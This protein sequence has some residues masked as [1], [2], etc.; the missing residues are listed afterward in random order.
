MGTEMMA[1]GK[2]K[3]VLLLMTWMVA[4]AEAETLPWIKVIKEELML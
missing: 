1:T 2:R 4:V 3:L